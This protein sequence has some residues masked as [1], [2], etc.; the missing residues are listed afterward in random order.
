MPKVKH[1]LF[2]S[3]K[4]ITLFFLVVKN[5]GAGLEN[6][7]SRLDGCSIV[8]NVCLDLMTLKNLSDYNHLREGRISFKRVSLPQIPHLQPSK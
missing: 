6:I 1:Y 2:R 3:I 5:V 4:V 7:C 8:K